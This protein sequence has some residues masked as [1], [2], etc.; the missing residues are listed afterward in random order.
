MKLKEIVETYIKNSKKPLTL[1]IVKTN[2]I[3]NQI[4]KS[5]KQNNSFFLTKDYI[6]FKSKYRSVFYYFMTESLILNRGSLN[7]GVTEIPFDLEKLTDH[8]KVT[9]SDYKEIESFVEFIKLNE[10]NK[11]DIN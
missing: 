10:L 1:D 6:S 8:F 7:G 11:L 4:Q 3:F 2:K 5:L 9:L